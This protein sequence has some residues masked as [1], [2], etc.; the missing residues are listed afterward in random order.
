MTKWVVQQ[1]CQSLHKKKITKL[2]F[3]HCKQF[4]INMKWKCIS[5]CK[6]NSLPILSILIS[7][8]LFSKV[9]EL[10]TRYCLAFVYLNDT[11][12]Y[13][14]RPCVSKSILYKFYSEA[15]QCVLWNHLPIFLHISE[16]SKNGQTTDIWKR[17]V[18]KFLK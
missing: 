7:I 11:L 10:N 9:S 14:S 8:G 4:C 1:Y 13:V 3:W 16:H 12:S 15:L 5:K 6:I 17:V 2:E 18:K